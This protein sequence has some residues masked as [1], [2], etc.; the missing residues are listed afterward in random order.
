MS[1]EYV[2]HP[3][4]GGIDRSMAPLQ[5]DKRSF[6]TLRNLRHPPFQRGTLEQTPYFYA[7]AT[8]TRGTYYAAG[9]QTEPTTSAIR[10]NT[11]DLTVTD[12]VCWDR[13]AGG[14]STQIQ[15][16]YQTT[17]PAANTIYTGCRLVI[18]S[19]T[20]L[21]VTLGS[22][23]D[24]EMTGAAAFRARK[25]GGAWVAG[26]PSTAGVSIDGGNA[27]LYFLANTGFAGTETWSWT[28]TDRS[29]A[30]TSFYAYPLLH[31]Y[32]KSELYFNSCDD[33][34]MVLSASTTGRY[35]IS[36]G[37]RPVVGAYMKFFD[38]HLVVG[39]FQRDVQTGAA[40]AR[41]FVVGWSDKD[42][43][44][45]FIPTDTNEADSY[46]LPNVSQLDLVP[47]STDTLSSF[48]VGIEIVQQQLF[49]FTNNETYVTSALGLPIVF[50]FVKFADVRLISYYNATI[51]AQRG[52][53]VIGYDD[54][55]YFNGA[56][57]QSIGQP[58]VQGT[59][60]LDFE[61]SHG[62]YDPFRRELIIVLEELL[63]V[64][65]EDFGTWYVR[66]V[67]F[68]NNTEPA[69]CVSTWSARV[70]VGGVSLKMFR[71]D[72]TGISQPV[73]D[74]TNGTVYAS[75]ILITQ[76]YGDVLGLVKET[77]GVY[78]GLQ[79]NSNGVDATYYTKGAS[80]TATISWYLC[81]FGDF[82]DVTIS[83][84]ANATLT[85]AM[86]SGLVSQP[87]VSFRGIAF[88]VE[89]A[90]TAAKP[91]AFFHL[92]ELGY[93]EKNSNKEKVEK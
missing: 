85:N 37:Y 45:N 26:V 64:Y 79:V 33:R 76:I 30:G 19:I 23:V 53:Y 67:D 20:G 7:Y 93:Y 17:V 72:L 63:Y 22:T 92:T 41:G 16:F 43:V 42:D 28:R 49:V 18:N 40:T 54:I 4:L 68:S 71:E 56:S 34:I 61:G 24:V 36:V 90:G 32:Y 74:W 21:A 52:V 58:I 89:I 91:A 48:I 2:K 31:I 51:Q 75:P 62:V 87:R 3:F 60:D 57:F 11:S 55:Y 1:L 82:D 50:S 35:A 84:D 6:Y 29:T 65:Q 78:L 10:L 66:A 9:S 83:T 80:I 13:I 86:T 47:Y 44:H 81:P 59:P 12:Y 15:V 8:F 38:N 14:A 77:S 70:V 69:T 5:A 46:T 88:V 39:W 27:T 25:N 73:F